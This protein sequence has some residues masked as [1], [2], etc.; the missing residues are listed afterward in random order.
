MP[1]TQQ[2]N[3]FLEK[4]FYDALRW[5]FVGAVTWHATGVQQERCPHQ[6][7]LSMYTAF[8]QARALYEF[9]GAG[10]R[11]DDVRA[12]HLIPSW[13]FN[14][15][16]HARYM[17]AGSPTNKRVFHLVYQRARHAG[18]TGHDGPDHLKNQ[19]LEIARDLRRLTEQF[20][21]QLDAR[22]HGKA[23]AALRK[24][25]EEAESVARFHGIAD[26]L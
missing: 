6:R 26:P 12:R 15:R 2:K 24:A 22:F 5:L 9:Y 8:V 19:V 25:V 11:G 14:S 7:V 1:T 10:G 4:D 13:R 21:S 18:G 17:A 16:L 3:D 20:V 23:A